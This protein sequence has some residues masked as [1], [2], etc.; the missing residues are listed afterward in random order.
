MLLSRKTPAQGRPT[1]TDYHGLP[2]QGAPCSHRLRGMAGWEV[3]SAQSVQHLL[4]PL[5]AAPVRSHEPGQRE[6]ARP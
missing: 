1:D 4:G 5:S 2:A 3:P 6:K